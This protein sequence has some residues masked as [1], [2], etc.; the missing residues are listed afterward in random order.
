M[1]YQHPYDD[2]SLVWYVAY[3]WNLTSQNFLEYLGI[4]HGTDP[5]SRA[6]IDPAY[7][8]ASKRILLNGELYFAGQFPEYG[9]TPPRFCGYR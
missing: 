3:S 9:R 6:I 1:P 2:E 4:A 8:R 5:Q 7:P